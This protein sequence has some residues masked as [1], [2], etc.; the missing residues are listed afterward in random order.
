VVELAAFAKAAELAIA[1]VKEELDRSDLVRRR[2]ADFNGATHGEELPAAHD[3]P[4]EVE[5]WLCAGAIT[6]G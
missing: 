3:V 1:P 6:P 2:S 4:V 5:G